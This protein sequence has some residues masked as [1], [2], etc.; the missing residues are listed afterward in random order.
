MGEHRKKLAPKPPYI[1]PNQ[2]TLV[3]FETPFEQHLR[4]DNRWVVLSRLVPWDDLSNIY[5]KHVGVSGMGPKPINPRI[6]IGALIIKHMEDLDDR[7]VVAQVSENVYMQYLLGYSSFN[8]DPPFDASLFVEIRKRLG[9]EAVNALN[10]KIIAIKTRMES[11]SQCTEPTDGFSATDAEVISETS[12]ELDNGSTL[13]NSEMPTNAELDEIQSDTCNAKEESR[14][15][16][17]NKTKKWELQHQDSPKKNKGRVIFDA[18]ACPQDIAYPNDLNLLSESRKKSEYLVDILYQSDLHSSKPRTYRKVARKEYLKTAMKK[19]K[20]KKE[21][22]RA[23]KKQL[24]YLKRNI[25]SIDKLL[26]AYEILPLSPKDYKYMLV[27]RTL[28]DQQE[29]MYQTKTHT[30]E[31]RIVSIHQPH[32]RPIVRGKAHAKVEFGS[33][34]HI[35]VIDGITF[36]DEI[37]WDAYDEGSHMMDYVEKYYQRFGFYP[38]EVL[39]DK[40]YCTRVNREKLKGK[41]IKLVGKSLGRPSAV[42]VHVSPGER[43][44][45]EGKFGQA[46]TAYG[47]GRIRARLKETSESWIASIIL[48]L[49]L[50]KLA[51]AVPYYL[52]CRHSG[53]MSHILILILVPILRLDILKNYLRP[54]GIFNSYGA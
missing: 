2:M 38:L 32:V 34:I 46:K 12:D 11:A 54:V 26:D 14:P 23:L 40:L 39:A 49:N 36:L 8:P 18:T 15:S 20:S 17:K 44:P 4:V 25:S 27:I 42:T 1:S 9:F 16:L 31:H 21:L 6:V 28:Y 29:T 5:L 48:V 52:Y 45:V 10:E 13:D 47:L 7:E 50:V 33:K 35:S 41:G 37:S 43:N 30:I 51:G 3:G 22:R 24:S 53:K 19:N